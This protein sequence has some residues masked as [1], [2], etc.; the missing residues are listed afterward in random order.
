MW[1]QQGGCLTG[2][3][4]GATAGGFQHLC[5]GKDAGELR[6]GGGELKVLC[7]GVAGA[8]SLPSTFKGAPEVPPV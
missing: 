3:G 2:T 7:R 5:C 8:R 1:E 6:E 4:L